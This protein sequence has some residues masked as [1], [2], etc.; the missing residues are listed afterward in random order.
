M[1]NEKPAILVHLASG[2]GNIVLATPLIVALEELG[3]STELWMHADYPQTAELLS[4]WSAVRK[5]HSPGNEPLRNR[6]FQ[7][8]VPAIPP[9]YWHR[10]ERL[11]RHAA[12]VVRR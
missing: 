9:F 1:E 2:I 8:V 4:N 12:H 10:F 11:Y 6:S 3:F 5:I 7:I